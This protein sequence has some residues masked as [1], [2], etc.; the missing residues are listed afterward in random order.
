MSC[1]LRTVGKSQSLEGRLMR[2]RV[3]RALRTMV[4]GAAGLTMWALHLGYARADAVAARRAACR[5]CD[6]ATRSRGRRQHRS[7]GLTISSRC[8]SCGCFIAPKTRLRL[9][10]CPDGHW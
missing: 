3:P 7:R 9:S 1:C 4:L 5:A 6:H 2:R 10:R 8:R